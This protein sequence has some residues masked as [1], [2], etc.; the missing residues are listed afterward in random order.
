MEIPQGT[1][2]SSGG[3]I[4]SLTF[5]E[6]G[7]ASA[8]FGQLRARLENDRIHLKHARVGELILQPLLNGDLLGIGQHVG[9]DYFRATE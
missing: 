8:P 2:V 3:I 1:F 9:F 7:S 6:D 4:S 5:T